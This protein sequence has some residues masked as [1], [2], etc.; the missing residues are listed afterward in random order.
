M[1]FN[2]LK[3]TFEK[4]IKSFFKLRLLHKLL[5]IF[6]FLLFICI[7]RNRLNTNIDNF[8]NN[9]KF[10]IKYGDKSYDKYYTKYYDSIFLN[11]KRNKFLLEDILNNNSDKKI[12]DIGSGTGHIVGSLNKKYDKV[13]GIDKSEAM[14]NY[15]NEIYPDSNFITSDILKFDTMN[16][17]KFTHATCL[18]RTIYDIKD[19][20][21]FFDVCNDILDYN[22]YL[23]VDLVD[24]DKFKPYIVRNENKVLHNPEKYGNEV[25]KMIV[26][27]DDNNEYTT[28]FE[29]NN[30]KS[31]NTPDISYYEEFKNFK[32][33]KVRKNELYLYIPEKK[34]IVNMAKDKGFT[35]DN[36]KKLNP[37]GYNN[38]YL[39]TFKKTM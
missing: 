30:K 3:K 23:I 38:E 6:V 21:K 32:N 13:I 12:L 18:N 33:N 15:A 39:Y 16:H 37:I 25:N 11:E 35:V 5:I 10:S 4:F 29:R 24:K 22:G 19:K 31:D 28:K 9:E 27:F 34:D 1:S 14:T 17:D 26:K 8:D 20:S 7:I 36:I 2:K